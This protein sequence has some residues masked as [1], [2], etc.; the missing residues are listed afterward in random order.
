MAFCLKRPYNIVSFKVSVRELPGSI[1]RNALHWFPTCSRDTGRYRSCLML[2]NNRLYALL[3]VDLSNLFNATLFDHPSF[4]FIRD[5]SPFASF[6]RVPLVMEGPIRQNQ[7]PLCRGS[8]SRGV[9]LYRRAG[10]ACSFPVRTFEGEILIPWQ[11][12]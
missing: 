4:N 12:Q 7:M 3:L 11:P 8:R 10:H 5:I 1:N 2:E 9:A 6:I